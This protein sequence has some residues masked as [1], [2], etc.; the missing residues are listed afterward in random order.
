M[1]KP[2]SH[3]AVN[4]G[5]ESGVRPT[6]PESSGYTASTDKS[7]TCGTCSYL[8]EGICGKFNALASANSV[9]NEWEQ[10]E[11]ESELDEVEH[12]PLAGTPSYYA[13]SEETD[14]QED[15]GLI[16]KTILKTGRWEMTPNGSRKPIKRP[17]IVTKTGKSLAS[18]DKVIVSLEDLMTAYKGGARQHVTIPLSHN[19]GL[20]ENTGHI[21][22]LR[23]VEEDGGAKL[24][25]GMEFTEPDI[26]EKVKRGTIANTSSGLL[27]D[28]QSKQDGKK[29]PVILDHAALTNQPW[30]VGMDPFGLSE[31]IDPISMHFSDNYND[32]MT[33]MDR[34]DSGEEA[35]DP[36]GLFQAVQVALEDW[37]KNQLPDG[38]ITV[39]DV[40]ES[41]STA[42]ARVAGVQYT[43]PFQ[44]VETGE[45]VLSDHTHWTEQEQDTADEEPEALTYSEPT[46]AD[47]L[48]AAQQSRANKARPST[49]AGSR[50]QVRGGDKVGVKTDDKPDEKVELSEAAK[51]ALEAANAR[52]AELEATVETERS[53][54]HKRAVNDR[55]EG[56]SKIGFAE[57]PGF[58]TKVREIMLADDGGA[59]LNLSEEDGA[60]TTMTAT[61]VIDAVLDALPKEALDKLRG[62]AEDPL[63]LSDEQKPPKDAEGELDHDQKVELAEAYLAG[64]PAKKAEKGDES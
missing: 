40:D 62:Q 5:Y 38:G 57:Y 39:E 64:K 26:R 43:I 60:T 15:D 18:D 51:T 28:Y 56:L 27:F 11:Y 47:R 10:G 30:I 32:P 52:I 6:P 33:G 36:E 48:K 17:M 50:T 42:Q 41:A 46:A 14:T 25:A 16:W 44:V 61:E 2:G 19:N 8:S 13:F 63:G 53:K 20:L 22:D 59:A 58:L 37:Q 12:T 7:K 55:I 45:V 29:W 21:R 54:S 3:D 9:C 34:E 49:T 4:P 1:A 35:P 23:I 24:I 31:D